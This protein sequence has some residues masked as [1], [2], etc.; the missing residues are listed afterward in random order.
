ML[1]GSVLASQCLR[2][3]LWTFPHK[4]LPVGFPIYSP[5]LGNTPFSLRP[6]PVLPFLLLKP[7]FSWN[8]LFWKTFSSPNILAHSLPRIS[9]GGVITLEKVMPRWG[10]QE[11]D[12]GRVS[13]VPFWS[14]FRFWFGWTG[15]RNPVTTRD[16]WLAFLDL[17]QK[18]C[19][20]ST[21]KVTVFILQSVIQIKKK[22]KRENYEHN[23]K[24]L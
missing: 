6:K 13:Q 16:K 12:H 10:R 24:P 9:L 1:V 17:F 7:V 3:P 15:R 14:A 23:R 2:P 20:C 21:E 4:S 8:S 19:L 5:P 11:R 22:K 18:P